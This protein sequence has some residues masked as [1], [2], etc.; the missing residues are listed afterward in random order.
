MVLLIVLA[1][2]PGA[3]APLIERGM[4]DSA[5]K[6]LEGSPSPSDFI[7]AYS[8]LIRSPY[9]DRIP[10]LIELGRKRFGKRFMN[11]EAFQ[12][13]LDRGDL[14]GALRELNSM[15]GF[16]SV[17]SRFLILQE[18]FGDRVW[19]ALKKLKNPSPTLRRVAASLLI[20]RGKYDEAIS[21]ARSFEDTVQI[22]RILM[23]KK[24]YD[25]VVRLLKKDYGRRKET[26]RLYGQA[27]YHMGRYSEAARVLE[28]VDPTTASMAY[29]KAGNLEKAERLSKD[30]LTLIKTSFARGDYGRTLRL[31]SST[32]TPECIAAAL[33]AHPD[34]AMEIIARMSIKARQVSPATGILIQ[35]ASAH[36]PD[37]VRM[38]ME[39]VLRGTNHR[40]EDDLYHLSMALRGDMEGRED[41]AIRHYGKVEGWAKPFALYRLYVLTGKEEYREELLNDY[42]QSAYS[43]MVARE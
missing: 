29:L 36:S 16:Q 9:S 11:Q 21:L 20:E 35:I 22:A 37:T 28:R 26:I 33:F 13:Y 43:M 10:R 8:L 17:R 14:N 7:L 3:I 27:L 19:E 6:I 42:P 18:K 41:M 23:G 39:N 31:C 40:L 25:L 5:L 12:Y 4:V 34:S 38:F 24:R 2:N 1:Q 32:L 15:Y 30:T